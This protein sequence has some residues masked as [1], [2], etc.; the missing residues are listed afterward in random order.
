MR[1]TYEAF[2][3]V[4]VKGGNKYVCALNRRQQGSKNSQKDDPTKKQDLD[5]EVIWN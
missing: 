4:E 2:I 3:L 5:K 1:G